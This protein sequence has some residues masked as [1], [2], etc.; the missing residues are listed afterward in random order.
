MQA[1]N[2]NIYFKFRGSQREMKKSRQSS[3][4]ELK[5]NPGQMLLKSMGFNGNLVSCVLGRQNCILNLYK[6]IEYKYKHYFDIKYYGFFQWK[7]Y[8]IFVPLFNEHKYN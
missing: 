3:L 2:C 7:F 6:Y 5:K 4:P 1:E 8:R